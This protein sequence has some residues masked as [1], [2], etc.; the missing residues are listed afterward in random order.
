MPKKSCSTFTSRA[1]LVSCNSRSKQYVSWVHQLISSIS[2]AR[3]LSLLQ[4]SRAVH[5]RLD[6]D[7]KARRSKQLLQRMLEG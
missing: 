1:A 4:A 7:S 3:L 6:F 2:W 5:T